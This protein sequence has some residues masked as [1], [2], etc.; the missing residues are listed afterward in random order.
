MNPLFGILIVVLIVFIAIALVLSF[1]TPLVESSQETITFKDAESAMKNLDS[2]I[3]EMSKE[4]TG[5]TRTTKLNFQGAMTV[6]PE[7][8]AVQYE[9]SETLPFIDS[10]SRILEGNLMIIS[11]ND[12]SC[13]TQTNLVMENNYLRAEFQNIP[14]ATPHSS[15]NTENNIKL[16]KEKSFNNTE[17]IPVNSSIIIDQDFTTGNGTGYSEILKEGTSL[18]SCIVHVF[19]NSTN[20]DYDAYYTLYAG[21]DFVV[22]EVRNVR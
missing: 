8:D 15:I 5:A 7:E 17:I 16:L 3:F 20:A 14:K 11:G 9:F 6:I 21:A 12:V 1:S 18:P 10:F 2:L 13:S 22:L 4:G 19:V